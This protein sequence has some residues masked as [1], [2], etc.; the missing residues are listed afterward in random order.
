[1][2]SK[3]E[4]LKYKRKYHQT[5]KK[6]EHDYYLRNKKHI[7]M[8]QKKRKKLNRWISSWE[9]AKQRCCNSKN[10]DYQWYGKRGIQFLLTLQDVKYLWFRD[11][12]NLMKR[13][14][15]DR[16]N[17]NKN[18]TL[19]NCRFIELIDNIKKGNKKY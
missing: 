12:A 13:P 8:N 10:P 7:L 6:E 14:S 2:Q 9:N 4:K 5:H 15:I 19:K 3:E 1:M 11:K 18:Y 16:I 17:N